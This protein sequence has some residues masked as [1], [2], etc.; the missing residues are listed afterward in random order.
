LHYRH[1][2]ATNPFKFISKDYD[3]MSYTLSITEEN[4]KDFKIWF[5][6]YVSSFETSDIFIQQSFKK[7]TD[8]SLE[9]CEEILNIGSRISL[10]K[11]ELMLAEAIALFHDIGRFEQFVKYETFVDS[12]SENHAE[13][14]VNVLRKNQVLDVLTE[15]N[16]EIIIK[17][18]IYHNRLYIPEG[19]DD[20][21]TLFSRLLRDADKIAILSFVTNYYRRSD[22]LKIALPDVPPDTPEIS[23]EI[24][25]CLM[26]GSLI[27][28]R[29]VKTLNDCKLLQMGWVYD[30]NFKPSLQIILERDYLKLIR[31][32]LPQS[33]DID[34]VYS[35]IL[36]FIKSKIVE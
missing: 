23:K 5:I 28:S 29:C 18:I 34:N 9:V 7:R 6:K 11:E 3:L 8:H 4:I 36:Q 31:D 13:L 19:E 26:M 2:Y 14:A 32:V 27:N 35:C 22:S 30:I 16:Q 20:S 1:D 15:T 33:R 25:D 10:N 21:V 12:K 24:M 17:A